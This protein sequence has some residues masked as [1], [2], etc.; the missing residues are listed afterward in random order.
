[1]KNVRQGEEIRNS[2]ILLQSILKCIFNFNCVY[3]IQKGTC[4]NLITKSVAIYKYTYSGNSIIILIIRVHHQKFWM[5]LNYTGT[6][7]SKITS[8]SPPVKITF[9]ISFPFIL[10]NVWHSNKFQCL[11]CVIQWKNKLF[12]VDNFHSKYFRN[13]VI[14]TMWSWKTVMN[15]FLYYLEGVLIFLMLF[16]KRVWE[17]S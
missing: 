15:R 16:F 2:I 17:T 3:N 11:L 6:L 13:N 14:Y 10:K 8:L 4:R 7:T 12:I 5:V 9:V 1:M